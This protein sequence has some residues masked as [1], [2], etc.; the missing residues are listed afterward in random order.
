MRGFFAVFFAIVIEILYHYILDIS[1]NPIWYNAYSVAIIVH[2]PVP[3][4]SLSR[5]AVSGV[6]VLDY[7]RYLVGITTILVLF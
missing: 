7:Y 4:M 6:S 3:H 5:Y 2:F 1:P